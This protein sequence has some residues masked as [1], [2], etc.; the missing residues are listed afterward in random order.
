MNNKIE[1][2]VLHHSVSYW[3]DGETIKHWH[4][5]K[6]PRGNGWKVPGYHVVICNGFTTY[7]SWHKKTTVPFSIGRVDRIVPETISTNGV[8]YGNKIGRAHV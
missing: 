8:K 6:K 5:D 1:H 3:G 7:N 2:I 4:C